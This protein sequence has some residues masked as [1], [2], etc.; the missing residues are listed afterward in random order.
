MPN[1][2]PFGSGSPLEAAKVTIGK[3]EYTIKWGPPAEFVLS[4]RNIRLQTVLDA[5]KH[6][7]PR[8][9]A[10]VMELLSACTAHAF[11]PGEHMKAAEF[12]ARLQ[13]GE[14]MPMWATL[15]THLRAEGGIVDIVPTKNEQ[16]PEAEPAQKIPTQ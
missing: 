13:P 4:S 10:M 3:S 12:G 2:R 11:P 1:A 7:E 9:L 14:F 16:V 15:L 6:N 5:A 8:F